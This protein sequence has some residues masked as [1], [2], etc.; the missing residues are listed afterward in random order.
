MNGK[1]SVNIINI[2]NTGVV[3]IL[4][5]INDWTLPK[6]C[7]L[8][9]NDEKRRFFFFFQIK[10]VR[11]QNVYIV[12]CNFVILFIIRS[13]GAI[14]FS[15]NIKCYGRTTLYLNLVFGKVL[16]YAYL[17]INFKVMLLIR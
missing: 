11:N 2:V 5:S 13:Y 15:G 8:M 10:S 17:W 7:A 12:R 3:I 1:R 9:K 16:K 14:I 4:I 6:R